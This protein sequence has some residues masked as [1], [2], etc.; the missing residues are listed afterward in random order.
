MTARVTGLGLFERR[1][2]RAA[3][4]LYLLSTLVFV[5][6]L[7]PEART[8]H[9]AFNHFALLAEAWLEGRLD[10]GGPPPAY[11][12]N[13]DF[14]WFEG[15]TYV[16]FPPLPALLLVPWVAVLGGA[17]AVPDALL[18]ALFA[19]LAPAFLLL[20]LEKLG[21]LGRSQLSLR[22]HTA[23][24]VC[25][26]FGSVYFFSAVEGT[27]WF[28]AHVVGTTLVAAY[29]L[30]A[31][32]GQRALASGVLLALAFLSR[33]PVIFGAL[34]FVV[35][36]VQ[37]KTPKAAACPLKQ[38]LAF[39][40]ALPA[41]EIAGELSRFLLPLLVAVLLVFVHNQLRF[42]DPFEF[43]YRYLRI[44]WQD[45]IERWGLF[46]Y[47][48]LA[49]NLGVV[50]TS[51][52]FIPGSNGAP[53]Q[54]NHHGLALWIT[55]PLYLALIGTRCLR[56]EPGLTLAALTVAL[57]SLL[58]QNTGWLQFGYRFSNDYAVFL[59]ALLVGA[60]FR[61]RGTWVLLAALALVVNAFGAWTFG[62]SEY[63]RFYFTDPT[64]RILY[65]P[66]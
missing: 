10:L 29:V 1:D 18:F 50:L 27:V 39:L 64:Q 34:L 53:F 46:D 17:A 8:Q 5:A 19:G 38:P 65:Q 32:G 42:G 11:A 28:A 4:G 51:L 7:R 3:A 36:L 48:Y 6:F 57:P 2:L 54:I 56:R 43:G 12:G 22:E 35:E 63:Q 61:L 62:R 60:G 41:R 23:L 40:R 55:T 44:T 37:A 9:T 25:F 14:A 49:K 66:D 31:V 24:A 13:N 59:F 20:A 16:V 47:H 15:R 26:A 58:Y 21:R 33:A 30:S 52:P 45:R